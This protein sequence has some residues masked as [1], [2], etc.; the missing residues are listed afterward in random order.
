MS[1]VSS[2]INKFQER[3]SFKILDLCKIVYRS[4]LTSQFC[5]QN[6]FYFLRYMQFATFSLAGEVIRLSDV[7]DFPLNL[8]LIFIICVAYYVAIFPFIALGL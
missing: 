7:K 2:G 4:C 3:K 5:C 6:F 8:W 1:L